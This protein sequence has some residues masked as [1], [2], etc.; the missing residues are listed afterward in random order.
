MINFLKNSIPFFILLILSG[1][2]RAQKDV[3]KFLGIPVDGFKADMINQ[4]KS[5]GFTISTASKD[6]LT[7]EFNGT[8]VNVHVVTNN[9]KVYRIMVADANKISEGDIKIRFNK[10][11]QQFHSN[12]NYLSTTDSVTSKYIIPDEE[13][14]SY[15]LLV[16]QKRYEAVFYQKPANYDSLNTERD[17]LF[18]KDSL[19]EADKTRLSEILREQFDLTKLNKVVWFMINSYSGKYYISMYYDNDYNKANGEDL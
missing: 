9:N 10:L 19:N 16:N 7:G 2:L 12:K 18:R 8:D 1:S 11:C 3:T 4:L 17:V 6:V 14:I 13:D 5:K 15:G